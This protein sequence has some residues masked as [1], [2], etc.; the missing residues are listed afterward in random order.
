MANAPA[1]TKKSVDAEASGDHSK[2]ILRHQDAN[3]LVF[4]VVGHVGSGTSVIAEHLREALETFKGG[5]YVT[6]ILK[7]REDILAWANA[8]DHPL[9]T[10]SGQTLDFIVGLQDLGDAFRSSVGD[11]AAVARALVGRIRAARA[12]LQGHKISGDEPVVPDGNRRAYILDSIRHPAEVHFLRQLYRSAFTLIGVVCDEEKRVSRLREH[13]PDAGTTKIRQF[14]ARDAKAGQPHGQRVSDTFH[15]ADYFLDNSPDRQIDQV[16]NKL[17]K[18]PEHLGR[19]IGLIGHAGPTE[20][21][22]MEETAMY[23]AYGAQMR[24]SCLSRHVGAALV[25]SDGNLISTGTN[26]VP[27]AG[28]G[29]YGEHFDSP[30]ETHTNDHRCAFRQSGQ[31]FCSNTREQGNIVSDL[32]Q[33]LKDAGVTFEANDK[34]EH[35]LQSSR[36]GELLEFSRAVHAEMDALL[37][38]ARKGSSPVGARMFVTTFPCHY[39]AR[40]LVSAGVDEVQFIEPY[41]KSKALTL[42]QDS[43]TDDVSKWTPP[44]KNGKH[45]LFRPFTGIAPRLYARVFLKDREWKNRYTGVAVMGD[46]DAGGQWTLPRVSYAQLEVDLSR[47]APAKQLTDPNAA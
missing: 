16:A 31:V 5:R 47:M 11:N 37:S 41:P 14:M 10:S 43:I 21:P 42:H 28:G 9:S 40:H 1:V 17:W 22:R 27:R 3:E 38:A 15:L 44:S 35:A 32:M 25:D 20:R 45:V 23:T 18:C 33:T 8:N 12:D 7:A 29:L 19:L 39:C 6:T 4:A 24:S 2:D 26:E 13:F 36:V 30:S 34:V 46:P